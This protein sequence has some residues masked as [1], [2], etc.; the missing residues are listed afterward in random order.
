MVDLALL[1]LVAGGIVY[2]VMHFLSRKK[3]RELTEARIGEARFRGL[4]EL[5]ADWFWE[6]DAEHK[7]TWISGGSPVATFFGGTPTYGKRFWEIP[8]VEV[9]LRALEALREGLGEQLPFFDLEMA[10]SDNRGARQI[11]IISG[12]S[13]KDAD[14]RFLGYRGVGRDVTEQRRAERALAEAKERLELA[15]GGANLAEWDYDLESDAI[16]LGSGWAGLLGRSPVAGI[17]SGTDLNE[18]VHPEDRPAV[19]T[20]FVAGLKGDKTICEVECRVRT[21]DGAW[22]WVHAKGQVT[23]RNRQGRATRASG[24]VTD[25]DDRK[26]AEEAQQKAEQRYRVLAELAPDGILVSFE[27]V[28]EYANPAAARILKAASPGALVGLRP[29]DL[30]H[31]ESLARYDERLRQLESAPGVTRF[32]DRR[33][34]CLD[35][36]PITVEVAS[37]SFLE[38]DRLVVLTVIRDV[39]EQR[40]SRAALAEREQRF[41]DVA[42]ASGEYVWETDAAWRFTYLSERVEAVLGYSRAELLGRRPQE[43]MPLGEVRAVQAWLAQHAPDGRPFRELVH[44]SL[45]KGG[46]VI[47]Q[48]VSGVPVRDAEGRLIGYRGTAADVTPRKQAE[49]RIEYLATRDALTGLPNRIL[50][51]DRGSQA[52]LHAARTRAQLAL[53]CIDLDRFKLV[54]ES[55]GHSAADGLLRAV[56]E[57][58]EQLAG[59]DTLARIGGDEYV[60]IRHIS[61]AEEAASHAQRILDALA[62]PFTLEGRSVSV[63]ASIGIS[64]Y[65]NDGRDLAGLLKCADAAMYQAKEGG[66]GTFRFFSPAL[67]AR[68]VQRLQLENELR[69]ALA[70]SELA[71]QWQPVV[72]GR[73]R[74]VGAEALVRWQHPGR[75]L[76]MPEDFVPLAEECGLIRQIGEW[77]LERA[78]SQAGAWQRQHPGRAWLAVNVSATE[79]AHGDAYVQKV[80][81]SLEANSLPG[82]MLEIEITERVLMAHLDENLET[83]RRLGALGVR[84][85][86]DDFG[87]GYSSLAYLRH[88]PIHKLKIDRSFLRAIDSHP[89]DEAI[90]QAIVALAR[91]LEIGTAAEG[92]E[93]E[94]QLS[95]LLALGVEEWQGHYFSAPLDASAFGELLSSDLLS[96][97]TSRRS[98]A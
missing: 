78:L 68:S 70:R 53:L 84:I 54:N 19:K 23:Q 94:A 73:R 9:D 74:V 39:T 65:P 98:E 71:L 35:G 29:A 91:T 16:Y 42:E 97:R 17:T 36:T 1:V 13:R 34:R 21:E 41:R 45:T 88:L 82:S 44:R 43:F 24:T 93:N 2:A 95:R 87:T 67:H 33:I 85:A 79:L 89:A 90:V 96:E 6:T 47:W 51:A 14:G 55:F 48:S 32:E 75:G 61:S 64:I 52:I 72:R 37:I 28:V 25:I 5:S 22:R 38:R 92:I 20:E 46:G 86:I 7:V 81:A 4:T 11:H 76:L 8:G 15:L 83:L 26:R 27:R 12:Q 60:F 10:R 69:G 59:G 66:R 58:L 80:A 77:T 31:P 30:M 18:M 40:A 63:G 50:L 62:R 3:D 57:R 56:A 49:A